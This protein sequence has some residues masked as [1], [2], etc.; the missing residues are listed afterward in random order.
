MLR[1]NPRMNPVRKALLIFHT[2]RYLKWTQIWHRGVFRLYH[3]KPN[4]TPSPESNKECRFTVAFPQMP[5]C[6]S[7]NDTFRFLNEQQRFTGWNDNSRDK[8]WLYNLHYFDW[9]RQASMKEEEGNRWIEQWIEENPAPAGNGWEPYTLSLRIVNWIKWDLSGHKLTKKTKDSLAVQIRFLRKRLEYH[10]LANHFLAN[11]KALVFAGM[12][13]TGAEAK[14]WLKK[15]LEIYRE[16]LPEQILPDGGHFELSPMYHSIILED[17]LDL[18][19]IQAPLE[20]DDYIDRMTY[21]LSVMTGP[22]GE[23]ALFNDAAHGIALDPIIIHNYA[24]S[25]GYKEKTIDES[26]DLPQSGYSRLQNGTFVCICDTGNIGPLYQPGHVHADALSFELW[27][28]GKKIL[29]NCG[30]GRYCNSPERI[31]QRSSAAH[32]TLSIDGDNSSEVWSAHRVARKGKLL[33]RTFHSNQCSGTF[34]SWHN[35]TIKRTWKFSDSNRL[36]ITDEVHGRGYHKLEMFFHRIQGTETDLI[37]DPAGV[38]SKKQTAIYSPS[39]GIFSDIPTTIYRLSFNN[40]TEI[41][42]V[43]S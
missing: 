17:L 29:T 15:G 28:N 32:N 6:Y 40:Q 30:T 22:D 36:E 12:F 43:I 24:E 35:T 27:R 7:G 16:Q 33:S 3:P 1:S 26:M 21:W 5:D 20:L 10:L 39:F 42:T 25:L 37:F 2:V 18:K 14:Q 19:N 34:R 13:F 31:F 11:A 8:L 41:K 9:L 38:E 23:I 4:F